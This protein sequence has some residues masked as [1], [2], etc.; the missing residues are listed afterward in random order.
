MKILLLVIG[1][2]CC[3]IDLFLRNDVKYKMKNNNLL[4]IGALLIIANLIY[5]WIGITS[6]LFVILFL[7]FAIMYKGHKLNIDFS[8]IDF[9]DNMDLGE[10][11]DN[12][13]KFGFY[14]IIFI[15]ITLFVIFMENYFPPVTL[16]NNII[17]MEGKYGGIFQVSDIHSV[18]TASSIGSTSVRRKGMSANPPR[19]YYGNF[20]L[21]N[22]SKTAKL[23]VWRNNPPY[24]KIRMNDNSLFILNFRN[25][26]ETVE[27]YKQ[28]KEKL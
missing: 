17:E 14:S 4:A 1:L 7:I 16:H 25:P 5:L 24:I 3:I 26:D 12:H 21:S 28:L 8:S 10:M 15:P 27:F 18:D 2:T 23:C 20:A 13:I 11:K 19:C 6:A 22:E 9:N